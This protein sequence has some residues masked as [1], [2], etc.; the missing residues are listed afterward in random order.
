M[1][2]LYGQYVKIKPEIDSAMQEVLNSTAFF[3]GRKYKS[4]IKILLPI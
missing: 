2:D 3:N 4:L 1:V